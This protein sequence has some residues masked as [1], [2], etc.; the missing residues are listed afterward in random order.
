MKQYV[1]KA[2]HKALRILLFP[3]R[4]QYCKKNGTQKQ[5]PRIELP[6]DILL[7]AVRDA[8]QEGHTATILIKGWSM[9]PFL[10]HQ[11][12]KVILD[13]P[14]G[15]QIGDAV[16]AEIVPGKFVLHRIIGIKQH[17]QD[18]DL[19]EI[20]LM[21]DGN[22]NG[23]EQCLRKNICGIVTHY[24]RPNRTIPANNPNLIRN[25]RIWK[26]LLP[27]RKYLLTIYKAII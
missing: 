4:L 23:T 18:K 20:T 11:R 12:D 2:I 17:A 25:I 3:V 6:N 10:E 9:R 26:K 22:V 14:Y 16:L 15:A 7:G 13:S 19:D 1:K 24:I 8:I 27:I 21:G 5:S